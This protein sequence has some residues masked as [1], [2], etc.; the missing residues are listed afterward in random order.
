MIEID[1]RFGEGGGQI[2]RTA[3]SLSVVTGK[4]FRIINIRKKRSKPG[5]RHQHLAC[6]NAAAEICGARCKGNT[7]QSLELEFTPGPIQPG[8]YFF[9]IPTAGSA[10]QVIQTVLPILSHATAPSTV[11]VRGGTHNPGAPPY[12]FFRASFL[13]LL[14]DLGIS[15]EIELRK[16][17]FFPVGGG[18]LVAT[19]H[20]QVQTR[21]QFSSHVRGIPGP[22]NA[23]ILISWLPLSIAERERQVMQQ[24]LNWPETKIQIKEI[25]DSPGPGNVILLYARYGERVHVFTAFGQ[26]GKPAEK[27]AAE[28]CEAYLDFHHSEAV[29]DEHLANQILLY[30]ALNKG[31]LFTAPSLS[32][33]TKTNIEVIK[34]F[35]GTPIK[36]ERVDDRCFE[37][38]VKKI[39]QA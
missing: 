11:T 16:H 39:E 33:H 21:G 31:G 13:P 12:E 38:Q 5:L 2:L 9:H 7:L 17:G 20:P 25:T 36:T 26:R 24:R 30:L 22:A 4:P 3:L 32:L 14:K 35:L 27:V 23:E 1:G 10:M 34:R 29:L 6:V 19:I 37:I 28:A 15:A 8:N 18:E